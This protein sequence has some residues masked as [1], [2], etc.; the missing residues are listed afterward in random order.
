ML[1]A[2]INSFF[3]NHQNVT[4]HFNTQTAQAIQAKQNNYFYWDLNQSISVIDVSI[5]YPGVIV[6]AFLRLCMHL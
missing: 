4:H 2:T 3:L 1:M 6:L 5:F